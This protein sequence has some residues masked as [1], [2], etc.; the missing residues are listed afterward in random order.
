[1]KQISIGT[2]TI[3][4]SAALAPMA[5][6]ADYAY[7]EMCTRY[8]AAY[9][10][11]EMVSA[12]ALCYG[13]KKSLTLLRRCSGEIPF[14]IQLFGDEPAF[15]AKAAKLLL[16]YAPDMIDINMGCPVP[17]V[18]GNGSG[19]ALMRDSAKAAAITAAVA[20]AV[21]VPVT[22]KIRK[23][24]DEHSVN[25]PSFA[26]LM[27]QSGAAAIAVH[28]RTK[29]QMYRP[30][31]DQEIIREVKENVSVPVIGNGGITDAYSAE[32]MY[33]K[34]GCDLVMVAQG[35]Y[36]RP[37][38][39]SEIRSYLKS[40][41]IPAEPTLREKLDI[42][43]EHVSLAVA[44]K[45]EHIAMMEARRV[46]GWYLKGMPGAAQFRYLC[47]SLTSYDDLKQLA[48]QVKARAETEY[49][50]GDTTK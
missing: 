11:S 8:G 46:A 49:D 19:S 1:M 4:Q 37:W 35:S 31:V 41:V 22:V 7:R 32:E 17:K 23:G 36:G 38:I 3:E 16:P 29:Q 18:A 21:P 48:A 47:S 44:D 50:V 27:E 30:P 34:T 2:V 26:R 6:V 28:G 14:S 5:S 33:R 45:G 20:E 9:T 15:M 43:L 12:K 40:G 13:D 24:W 42:M 10:V 39:F 25:A